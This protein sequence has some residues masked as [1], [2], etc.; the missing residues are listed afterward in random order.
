MHIDLFD[1]DYKFLEIKF[2]AMMLFFNAQNEI[3]RT[4]YERHCMLVAGID[5]HN[6][7]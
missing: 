4:L 2:M 6:Q 7:N 3:G 1:K 5:F